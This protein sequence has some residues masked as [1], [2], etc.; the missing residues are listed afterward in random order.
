MAPKGAK[1][2]SKNKKRL[3]EKT[4]NLT[5]WKSS[6]YMSKP[7]NKISDPK[8]IA[9]NGS[10]GYQKLKLKKSKNKKGN[11]QAAAELGKAQPKLGLS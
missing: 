2:L 11:K 6:A 7:Q 9:R 1:W 5:K 8:P 10:K 3:N 4:R